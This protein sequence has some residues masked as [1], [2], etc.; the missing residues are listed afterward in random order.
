MEN[1]QKDVFI[2]VDSLFDLS[3]SKNVELLAMVFDYYSM[4][5]KWRYRMLT[6]S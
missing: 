2:V 3:H 1:D 5:Y 6:L 4:R